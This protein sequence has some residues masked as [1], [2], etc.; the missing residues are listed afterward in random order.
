VAPAPAA[1]AL[2]FVPFSAVIDVAPGLG[3]S[4]VPVGTLAGS[5]S[6]SDAALVAWLAALA[7][8]DEAGGDA[9]AIDAQFDEWSEESSDSL[10]P[11]DSVFAVLG[12]GGRRADRDHVLG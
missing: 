5:S 6:A 8:E 12:A 4:I 1:A 9:D 3:G 7:D 10:E 11:I 2:Q